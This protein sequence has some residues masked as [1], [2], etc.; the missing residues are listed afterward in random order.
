[1][2]NLI[3]PAIA[4]FLALAILLALG[5]WQLERLAWKTDLIETIAARTTAPPQPLPPEAAWASLQPS[6]YAYRHVMLTGVFDHAKESHVFRPLPP[7]DNKGPYSG[8]GD[9]VLTP[10]HL[11]TGGTVLVNRGF[12]PQDHLDPQTRAAGQIAGT[13]TL[14][15]L[16]RE[17]EPR[18]WFTPRDE[19]ER[20]S[21]FTRDPV[22]MAR[23]WKLQ[24]AAPF[25]VDADAAPIPG[26]LPQGGET[27][28]SIPN[29]HLSYALTW[30]GLAIGL[31][32]VFAVFA[33]R[34]LAGTEP[35]SGTQG[36]ISEN[37]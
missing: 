35:A 15:G 29:S 13:V 3:K 24:D 22:A 14:T 6:D 7:G 23:F 21:W 17:P 36:R 28:L 34:R 9:V 26:G 18:T 25:T 11:S 19:P 5:I 4:A 33:W 20:G 32:G 10:F 12:V 30:F 31:C 1:M 37:S 27:V 8:I 16:M 2:R